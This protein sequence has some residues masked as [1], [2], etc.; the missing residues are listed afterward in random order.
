MGGVSLGFSR[1]LTWALLALGLWGLACREEPV[2]G[3]LPDDAQPPA[4]EPLDRSQPSLANPGV[5]EGSW[6]WVQAPTLRAVW[7]PSPGVAWAVGNEGMMLRVEGTRVERQPSLTREALVD[8]WGSSAQDLWAVGL[9]G[10]LMH[11]DGSQWSGVPSPVKDDLL[12]VWGTSATSVWAGGTGGR[13]L[14]WNGTA[15]SPVDSGTGSRILDVW[16]AAP[17][18]LWVA[19]FDGLRRCTPAGCQAFAGP[20]G[21]GVGFAPVRVRGTS[22]DDVYFLRTDRGSLVVNHLVAGVW[23]N[24]LQLEGRGALELA[25]VGPEE[26]F[27]SGGDSVAG[28]VARWHGFGWELSPHRSRGLFGL[29]ASG[30][31]DVWA[32]GAGGEI[33]RKDAQGWRSVLPPTLLLTPSA[34][35]D[36]ALPRTFS[37]FGDLAPLPWG[38][39]AVT[40]TEG[41]LWA[42]ADEIWHAEIDRGVRTLSVSRAQREGDKAGQFVGALHTAPWQYLRYGEEVGVHGSS[43]SNVWV[44]APTGLYHFDGEAFTHR[45]QIHP[46]RDTSQFTGPVWAVGRDEAWVGGK[47]GLFH[48]SADFLK[49]FPIEGL[50]V[51][52][53]WGAWEKELWAVGSRN[54]A[55]SA[56]HWEGQRWTEVPLPHVDGLTRLEA[57]TGRCANEV[58]AV[59]AQAVFRWDGEAWHT[60]PIPMPLARVTAAERFGAELWVAGLSGAGEPVILRHPW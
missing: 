8:L 55:P 6:C 44:V 31:D 39:V 43:A 23:R 46:D 47:N 32:V 16:A 36:E 56:W 50:S 54:G 26:L 40:R 42:G 21:P 58:Y 20:E 22:R 60:V 27:I 49:E 41:R 57:V 53:L 2:P 3:G 52:G 11:W 19:T 37:S 33:H 28:L 45:T 17:E 13:L 59:G 18:E 5:C 38:G 35:N 14:H 34:L 10:T 4:C 30:R 48:R 24:R 15:W 51:T 7:S 1:G 29:W 25:V 12:A 9:K